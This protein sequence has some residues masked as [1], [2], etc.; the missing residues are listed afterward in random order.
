MFYK[1]FRRPDNIPG[2]TGGLPSNNST[3]L[4]VMEISS[5]DKNLAMGGDTEA[6]ETFA[7]CE[8]RT[9]ANL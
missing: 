8:K 5:P 9:V 3:H 7:C 4:C 2:P 6:K 1:A